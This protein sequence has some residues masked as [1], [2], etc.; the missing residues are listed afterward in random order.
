MVLGFPLSGHLPSSLYWDGWRLV[1]WTAFRG[2]ADAVRAG[3]QPGSTDIRAQ[4]GL[5]EEREKR[6]DA[7][8]NL[9]YYEPDFVV[10]VADGRHYLIETKGREDLDVAHKDRAADLWCENATFLTGTEWR[11]LLSPE[12]EFDKL[13]PTIFADLNLFAR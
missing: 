3:C 2:R 10:T 4:Y 7:A 11:Y 5:A 13:Q 1:S 6:R 8:A 12:K 9:R